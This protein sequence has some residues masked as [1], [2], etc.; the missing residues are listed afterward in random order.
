MSIPAVVTPGTIARKVLR[1]FHDLG[2]WSRYLR[3]VL[4]N[5]SAT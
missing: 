3:R 5:G 4:F 2:V 1:Q